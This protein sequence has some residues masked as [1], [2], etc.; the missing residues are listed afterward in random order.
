M[1]SPWWLVPAALA[2]PLGYALVSL[3]AHRSIIPT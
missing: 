2:M 1:I 3:F